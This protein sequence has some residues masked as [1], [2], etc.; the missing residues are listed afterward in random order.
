[1][2]RIYLD[3]A[4][5]TEVAPEVQ[6]AMAPWLTHEFGNPSS[7]HPLGVRAAEAIGRARSQVARAVGS[8]K[9]HVIFTGGGT[10][11]N[12]LGVLGAARARAASGRKVVIGPTEHSS[13]RMS[14]AAL[15]DE[16]FELAQAEL[17]AQGALD[18]AGFE[19]LLDESTVLVAQMLVNNEYGT[20]YPI[21][22]L[23][24]IVRRKAP[25]AHFHVDAVQGLG[26]L[27]LSIGELGADSIAVSAH[28][29]H[30]P[31]GTGALVTNGALPLRPLIFGGGQEA[32]LRAGTE[33]V[34]GI[35]AFGE[36]AQL[37][38]ERWEETVEAARNARAELEKGIA[39]LEGARLLQPGAER[40][41]TICS[42]LLPGAPAEVWMHHLESRGV[43]VSVGAA[44][45]AKSGTISPALLALHLTEHEAK[46]V[47]RFSFTRS[48]VCEDV[49][50][51]AEIIC[52]LAP[53]LE[54]LSS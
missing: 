22:E 26:K 10:E 24:R 52:E 38:G 46:R 30:A 23:A 54:A 4:A 36:A 48:T 2:D 7:R 17:D 32:G 14:A 29:V 1:M 37:A 16:G 27:P 19:A 12:N 25:N 3:N 53:E 51:A 33:N 18:L 50:R 41:P 39:R 11:A 45:Q 40:V 13:V 49:E 6:G 28:K 34:V 15:V 9:K 43:Y 21:A 42:I 47:L 20:I 5:T 44:C 35:V 31:K 8:R